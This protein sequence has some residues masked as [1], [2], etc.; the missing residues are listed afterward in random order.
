M[1]VVSLPV[2]ILSLN[3]SFNDVNE[4]HNDVT[5]SFTQFEL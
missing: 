5:E 3:N 2:Y 4:L 1:V